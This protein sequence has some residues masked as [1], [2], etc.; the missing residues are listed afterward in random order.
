[1]E[2][3]RR[4]KGGEFRSRRR[5]GSNFQIQQKPGLIEEAVK[6]VKGSMRGQMKVTKTNP[7]G[8]GKF[9]GMQVNAT[10]ER[11]QF[12]GDSQKGWAH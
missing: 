12:K 11:L 7:L 9:K 2:I 6:V 3:R 5:R 4:V 8:G 1:M 10:G